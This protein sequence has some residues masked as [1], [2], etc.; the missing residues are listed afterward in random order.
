LL[1]PADLSAH[2]FFEFTCVEQNEFLCA[3][4]GFPD[5]ENTDKNCMQSTEP[6]CCV[7]CATFF[8]GHISI[9]FGPRFQ[10]FNLSILVPDRI[11][12]RFRSAKK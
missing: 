6:R 4:R 5:C 2:C 8:L 12:V 11:S 7:Y 3:Y 9:D 1:Y 10:P